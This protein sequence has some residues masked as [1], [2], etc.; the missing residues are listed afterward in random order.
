MQNMQY[1]RERTEKT[2]IGPH[3]PMHREFG[4]EKPDQPAPGLTSRLISPQTNRIFTAPHTALGYPAF[5]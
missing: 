3:H 1:V 2:R 5:T 4:G